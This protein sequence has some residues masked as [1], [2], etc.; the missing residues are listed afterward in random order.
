[1]QTSHLEFNIKVGSH[2]R[3]QVLFQ[4]SWKITIKEAKVGHERIPA[5]AAKLGACGSVSFP[6][7]FS[8]RSVNEEAAEEFVAEIDFS[9]ADDEGSQG[10]GHARGVAN[11]PSALTDTA[12]EQ[13]HVRR[14]FRCVKAGTEPVEDL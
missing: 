6:Q 7:R 5:P 13:G 1:M 11:Q 4:R 8:K 3:H 10:C 14:E 2:L 12:P 9:Q